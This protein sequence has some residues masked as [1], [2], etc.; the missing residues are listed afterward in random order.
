MSDVLDITKKLISYPSITPN[1]QG[2]LDY[3]KGL[4]DPI[5]FRVYIEEFSDGDHKVRNLYAE[6]GKSG[7]NLCFA[8]HIDV[9][10][11]VDEFAWDSPPFTANERDGKLYGRGS[12]DMKGSIGAS[13]SAA[14]KFVS[15]N[16]NHGGKISFLITADEEEGSYEGTRS[17]L[18]WMEEQNIK[19]DFA[20]VG[21]PTC[22]KDF[23]DIIKIGRRGSVNFNLIIKGLAGHVAYPDNAKNPI[24]MVSEVISALS[25]VKLDDGNEYFSAS[26]LEFTTIDVGNIATNVIP[27]AVNMAFNIRFNNYHNAK[28]LANNIES[29]IRDVCGDCYELSYASSAESFLVE[30]EEFH[31]DFAE[32]VQNYSGVKPK[33]STGGGTSDARFIKDYC[34]LLEFGVCNSSAHKINEFVDISDLQKLKNVYYDAILKFCT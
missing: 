26:N 17:M 15:E 6:H 20:V 13:L 27:S 8:G 33:F 25:D 28:G 21:E 31:D 9:V 11:P 12:C 3:I 23:G 4:L 7:K 14:I 29:I 2:G 22:E 10:H 34:S 32:I 30:K 18:K 16:P 24:P 19:I 1:D 5:G